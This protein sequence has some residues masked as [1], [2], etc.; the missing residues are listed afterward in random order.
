MR[1]DPEVRRQMFETIDRWKQSGLSQKSFCENESLKAHVF[2][3]W[4]KRYRLA[5]QAAENKS[6]FVKLKIEKP[7][8][9]APVEIHFPHGVRLLFHEA[10]N[11]EYLKALIR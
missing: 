5:E 8:V 1:N 6:G 7:A 10:V 9:A 3:Y 4:Y 2:H 11:P